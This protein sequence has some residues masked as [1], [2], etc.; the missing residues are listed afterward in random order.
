MKRIAILSALVA[1]AMVT[2]LAAASNLTAQGNIAEI[3]QALTA[4][5]QP[6]NAINIAPRRRATCAMR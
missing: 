1:L 3:E 2:T 6:R 5:L 4:A